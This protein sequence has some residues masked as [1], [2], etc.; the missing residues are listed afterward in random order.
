MA[1]QR[2]KSVL[3]ETKQAFSQHLRPDNTS[4]CPGVYL[5]RQF[6]KR[7]DWQGEYAC[8]QAHTPQGVKPF[9]SRSFSVNRY[10]FDEAYALA[11]QA[12]AEFITE[13]SGFFGVTHIPDRFRPEGNR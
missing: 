12:R 2:C 13:A 7:G 5:R 8:W 11:V 3:P 4:G 9:R 1:R 10:G 6:V